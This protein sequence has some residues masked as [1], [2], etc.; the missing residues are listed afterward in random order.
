MNQETEPVARWSPAQ[1]IAFRFFFSYF[2]LF[3]LTDRI[4]DLLPWSGV[5][6]RKYAALW[7]PIIAGLEKHFLHTG[8]DIQIIEG[9]EG[10]NNTAYGTILFLC[11]VT[12]AAVV[13]VLW[14][15]LDRRR[16]GYERLHSWFRFVLRFSLALAMISYGILKV[17]PT[18]MIAP[19]PLGILTR[20]LGDFTPMQLLWSFMGASPPYESLTGCAELLGGVLLLVPRTTLL[21]AL[22]CLGDM[23]MVVTLNFCYDVH[24]KLYSIHLLLMAAL[25]VAPDLGRLANLFLFNRGVEPATATPLFARKGL[26]RAAQGFLFLFGLYMIG[27]T[28]QE[29]YKRYKTFHPPRPPLYGVWSVEEL[30]VDGREVPL[31]TDP[32]RWRWVFFQKPGVLSVELM[33]GSRKR[34]PLSLDLRHRTMTLGDQ[35]RF[36]LDASRTDTLLLDGV[37]DGHPT[38]ARLT[39]MALTAQRF[40]WIFVPPKEDR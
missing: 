16:A 2:C 13:T 33:I 12:L 5:L 11:Y 18:Q 35:A 17:I 32:Q 37:L 39:R 40:H 26:D 7:Y 22:V 1:R 10:V 19:P 34:Y 4:V 23:A 38:R 20:R 21:G 24:V 28:F 30:A 36:S 6:T 8:Y 3:F 15:V 9:G 25:L 27:T 31:F 29:T 14:S